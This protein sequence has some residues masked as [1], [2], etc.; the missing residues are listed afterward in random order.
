MF[1]RREDKNWIIQGSL[2]VETTM[3]MNW[4]LTSEI[5]ILR[6]ILM[7]LKLTW[8]C[9]KYE[10]ANVSTWTWWHKN[11]KNKMDSLKKIFC[12]KNPIETFKV[13]TC[14]LMLD[15]LSITR[16]KTELKNWFNS[17]FNFNK[18]LYIEDIW[19]STTSFLQDGV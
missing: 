15:P 16:N 19:W 5:V 14:S 17:L 6:Q 3:T 8:T 4:V 11:N 1:K 2:W 7:F 9:L 18:I 13:E 10:A 12:H